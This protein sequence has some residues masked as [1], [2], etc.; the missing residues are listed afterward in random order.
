M[1]GAAA[2]VVRRTWT[3]IAVATVGAA[4]LAVATGLPPLYDLVVKLP[5][6]DATNNGRFA[7]ITILCL[8]VLAGWGLDEL[9]VKP[10]AR[11]GVVLGVAAVLL[12][13]PV[14]IAV[15]DR[16]FGR[17]ALG[18]AI[19]VAWGFQDPAAGAVPVVKLAAVLEWVVPAGA[20]PVSYTH[21]TLPTTPY[22]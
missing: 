12:A 21:L 16:E 22:V 18:M 9:T 14:V 5:G 3:R 7:V 20:A 11:C 1:L 17:H 15:G 2:L 19:K 4:T 13:L 10:V 8:A 6:F